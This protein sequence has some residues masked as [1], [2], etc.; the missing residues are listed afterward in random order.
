MQTAF[1]FSRFDLEGLS[2]LH[3]HGDWSPSNIT[4]GS[5]ISYFPAVALVQTFGGKHL[6]TDLTVFLEALVM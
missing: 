2:R 4:F 1:I 5:S 6:H 3:L